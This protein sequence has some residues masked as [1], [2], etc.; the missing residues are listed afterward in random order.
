MYA[1]LTYCLC[2]ALLTTTTT[3]NCKSA[4]RVLIMFGNKLFE[5]VVATKLFSMYGVHYEIK[6]KGKL[7]F[8]MHKLERNKLVVFFEIQKLQFKKEQIWGFTN[9]FFLEVTI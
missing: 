1:Q 7:K 6:M 2:F 9:R 3:K 5:P 4:L 8:E